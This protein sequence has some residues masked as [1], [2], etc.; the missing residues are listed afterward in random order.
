MSLKKLVGLL[1]VALFLFFMI[2]SPAD[3]AQVVRS[4]GE[5]LGDLFGALAHG[6]S[7]FLSSL[8]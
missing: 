3:A 1:L 2:Q 4:A 5:S 8:F 7:K 6:F